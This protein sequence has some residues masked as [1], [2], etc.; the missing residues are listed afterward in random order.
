MVSRMKKRWCDMI[1]NMSEKIKVILVTPGRR[2]V[3]ELTPS[4]PSKQ[5]ARIKYLHEPI[6]LTMN[7]C[8]ERGYVWHLANQYSKDDVSLLKTTP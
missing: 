5:H 2:E 8:I 7:L 1:F 6:K 3:L 4:Q